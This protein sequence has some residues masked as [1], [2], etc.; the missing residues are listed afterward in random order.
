MPNLFDDVFGKV[1]AD[2]VANLRVVL[3]QS[4][5]GYIARCLDF[6]F[7]GEGVS[8]QVAC[9]EIAKAVL[10]QFNKDRIAN[11][12][13]FSTNQK[14]TEEFLEWARSSKNSVECLWLTIFLLAEDQGGT[15]NFEK[16]SD[17][18]LWN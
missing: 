12:D 6:E 11:K 3:Y 14:P 17:S 7:V 2:P 10:I 18:K 4:D 5:K 15:H 8:K 16:P 13:I 9:E 1:T